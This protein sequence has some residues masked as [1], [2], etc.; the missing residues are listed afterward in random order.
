MWDVQC[1]DDNSVIDYLKRQFGRCFDDV[2]N[3]ANEIGL[4]IDQ[5][6]QKAIDNYL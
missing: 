3:L 1:A 5:K 4:A 6:D 2:K